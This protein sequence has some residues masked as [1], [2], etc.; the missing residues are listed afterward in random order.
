MLYK[1]PRGLIMVGIG[2]CSYA[3]GIGTMAK[4]VRFEI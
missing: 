1:D 3:I 4:M 2:L